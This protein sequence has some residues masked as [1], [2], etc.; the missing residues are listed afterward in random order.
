MVD[1]DPLA[2][3]EK[4]SLRC[5]GEVYQERLVRYLKVFLTTPMDIKG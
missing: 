5:F 1:I 3:V 2:L 4:I